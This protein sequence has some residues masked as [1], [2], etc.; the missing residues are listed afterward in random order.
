LLPCVTGTVA[1]RSRAQPLAE[2]RLSAWFA[3]RGWQPFPFQ[4]RVWREAAS[5]SS[6]LLHAGT[7]SGK[8]LAVWLGALL[9]VL[10][11]RKAPHRNGLRVLWVTPMRALAA[12]TVRALEMPLAGLGLDYS[13]GL[14]TGDT[15]SSER[16]RQDRRPPFALVTT[17]ESLSLMIS[18]ADAP[19]RLG[20]V[21]VVIVDEWHELMGGKRGVQLQ[22][23]LARI[24]TLAGAA[25]VV[26]GVSATLGNPA[27]A[28]DVLLGGRPGVLVE[29]ASRRSPV[30]DTLLPSTLERFPWAGHLGARMLDPVVA[31]LAT[32]ASSLVFC[33]TRAQA[34]LWYAMIL[35]ARPDWA[36]EIALH[37]GSLDVDV[38]RWVERAIGDGRLR[39]VVCT[40]SLDLGVD[41][42]PV[43]RVLQIG[44]AKGIGRLLQRA[45]R[46]GHRPG[47]VSRVT[48]V[49]THA[50]ELIEAVA[51]RDAARAG[52]IE[53]R[54]APQCPI[55]VLVQ[56]LVTV[57]VGTGFAE[58]TLLAE[59]RSTHA[60][61]TLDDE[62][63]R[64]A[65]AFVSEGAS[66]AAYPE[67]RKLAR[68]EDG[69]WRV[70]DATIARRHRM[71][72]GTIVA[73]AAIE[74]RFMNGARLGTVEEAFI[75]RLRPGDRFMFGGRVLELVRVHE[76][77]AWVRRA[78][79]SSGAVPRWS[80][81]RMPLSGELAEA[82]LER[83]RAA[84]AGEFAGPEMRAVRPLLD[85]QARWSR[86]PV[87]EILLAETLVS[88]EGHHLFV[89]PFAGRHANLGLACVLAW[90]ASRGQPA[91]I[92]VAVNDYG[93]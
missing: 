81:G 74:L 16:A 86:L 4:R 25:P 1:D 70:T 47:A 22:L 92:S 44:S 72:I 71:S 63:W 87:P 3:E 2:A 35:E 46:S 62:T 58:A 15:P 40:S 91:T 43:E 88:R 77:S 84:A 50:L 20:G 90:R 59:L 8:T 93:F 80:G 33:N 23:A 11:G 53:A 18:R 52:R 82:V 30:I 65:L 13:V 60:Y 61:R 29:A 64:W 49:P 41:F 55:D 10:K 26:W 79:A 21:E 66:L 34:E 27:E 31:E 24:G 67:Y 38:R 75:A 5:G 57:G 7:G 76:M 69:L 45:G 85:L 9:R 48:L 56:H 12:D 68:G 39:A 54:L 32:S 36:G 42:S 89:Y 37:H 78:A 83:L 6:G 17:P 19:A 28:L 73:D 14:R 51:A